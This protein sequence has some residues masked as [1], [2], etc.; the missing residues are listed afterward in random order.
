[1]ITRGWVLFIPLI[2]A[3]VLTAVYDDM[4]WAIVA[5]TYLL[6][7]VPM[8]ITPIAFSHILT[9]KARRQLSLKSVDIKDDRSVE[10]R[11]FSPDEETGEPV[12]TDSEI[13][14]AAHIRGI[15]HINS[16]TIVWLKSSSIEIIII[17]DI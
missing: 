3:L 2:A 17:P 13:I 6:V 12:E 8:I 1:M 15:F 16:H 9:P 10:I 11:Y 14:P 5:V 4:R 7:C